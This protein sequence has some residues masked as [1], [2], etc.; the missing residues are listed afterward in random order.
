M[1][2]SELCTEKASLII[3]GCIL[4]AILCFVVT[5]V[6][7]LYYRYRTEIHVYCYSSEWKALQWLVSNPDYDENKRYD[8][9]VSYANDDHDFVVQKLVPF[10]EGEKSFKLCLH[11]RD[12]VPGDGIQEQI[13]RSVQSSRRTIVVLSPNFLNSVW[14]T[15]EFKTAHAEALKSGTSK[16]IVIVYEDVGSTADLD[17]SLKAYLQMNTYLKWETPWF[18]KQLVYALPHPPEKG[19]DLKC[20]FG[21]LPKI[22]SDSRNHEVLKNV[23][24]KNGEVHFITESSEKVNGKEGLTSPANNTTLMI[25]SMIEETKPKK[26]SPEKQNGAAMIAM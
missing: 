14:G 1:L 19:E 9:F 7:T 6:I 24:L 20:I 17:E 5:L 12:W 11:Y 16:V 8:A 4:F 26:T 23:Q 22:S 3:F 15:V 10:L 25:E 2:E 21:R 13:L 18:W